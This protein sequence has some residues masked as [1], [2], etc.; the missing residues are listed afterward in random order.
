MITDVRL[1]ALAL[2]LLLP[3]LS[4]PAQ[5]QGFS[6]SRFFEQCLRFEAGGDLDSARE[7]CL[8]ALKADPGLTD[9]QLAAARIE[10]ALGDT[11]SAEQRLLR[12][13]N[14]VASPE[15]VI[16]LAEIAIRQGRLDE[17]EGYLASADSLL[18]RDFNNELAAR[19]SYLAGELAFR[20]GEFQLALAGYRQA[21]SSEPLV[22]RYYLAA[23]GVLLE[24]GLPEAA[25]DELKGYRLASGEEGSAEL[26]ALLGRAYWS[27]GLLPAAA[28]ELETAAVLRGGRQAS[29][30]AADLR[31]VAA[32]YYGQGDLTRGNL[33]LQDAMRQGNLLNLINGNPLLWLLL[34]L[35]IAGAHLVGEGRAA[36]LSTATP[37]DGARPWSIAQT[38]GIL[39]TAVLTGLA[40]AFLYGTYAFGNYLAFLTPLQSGDTLAVFLIA[41]TLVAVAGAWRRL[42]RNGWDPVERLFGRGDHL[43]AGIGVGLLLLAVTLLYLWFLPRGGLY[44]H[45]YF[46]LNQLSVVVLAAMIIVPFSE[47]FFRAFALPPFMQRYGDTTAIIISAGLYALV[48]GT[49][50]LLL[51]I[52]GLITAAAFRSSGSGLLVFVAQLTLHAGLLLAVTFSSLA[53]T[54]FM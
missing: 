24:L 35:L 23:A 37:A 6:A 45:F 9:A 32:I 11:G 46:N 13:R 14:S 39:L 38:Y 27:A 10:L 34:L 47:L 33:A 43:P 22:G 26:H 30:R 8:N 50:V 40:A 1:A 2:L 15:P 4:A 18:S 54:L 21:S 3:L 12:I 31:T 19:R 5:A 53:A 20:R 42:R 7:S 16:L 52:L 49:P 44:G 48:L 28:A 25:A 29:E 41:F 36:Q 17:A 51:L